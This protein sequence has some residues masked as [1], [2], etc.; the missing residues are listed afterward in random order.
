MVCSSTAQI[1]LAN[2]LIT[3]TSID[4]FDCIVCVFVLNDRTARRFVHGFD[5]FALR[6]QLNWSTLNR[7]ALGGFNNPIYNL[8]FLMLIPFNWSISIAKQVNV[9]I[10]NVMDMVNYS[11][12]S[13]VINYTKVDQQF[14]QLQFTGLLI[15]I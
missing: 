9:L 6:L 14:Q 3:H 1:D 10:Y 7:R 12:F 13:V 2:N 8:F 11:R 4:W 5:M 15:P